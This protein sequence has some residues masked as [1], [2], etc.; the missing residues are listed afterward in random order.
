[1]WINF[2]THK[3]K[4]AQTQTKLYSLKVPLSFFFPLKVNVEIGEKDPFK[5]F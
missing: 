2:H 5:G 3:K 1:M 4:Q